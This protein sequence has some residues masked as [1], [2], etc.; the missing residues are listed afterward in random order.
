MPKQRK[1]RPSPFLDLGQVSPGPSCLIGPPTN[2]ST[3]S[4][5][6]AQNQCITSDDVTNVKNSVYQTTPA[7]ADDGSRS[8][9]YVSNNHELCSSSSSAAL[10]SDVPLQVIPQPSACAGNLVYM[11][12]YHHADFLMNCQPVNVPDLVLTKIKT[13]ISTLWPSINNEATDICPE[14]ARVYDLVK[15]T[16]LPNF[17]A[18][19]VPVPSG[20]L[21]NNWVRLL[22]NYHDNKLCNFLYFG[23]PLGY[24][25]DTIPVTVNDNH[26]SALAYPDHVDQFISTEIGF[27]ALA[28][29]TI[30]PPFTPWVRISPL[31]TR[32]KKGSD[33]RRIIVDLTYPEGSAVNSGIQLS[34]YL[35]RDITYSLPT[36][37]DLTTRL[38]DEE[39]GAL[40]WKADLARAYR[41]LRADPVDAP[42]LGIK[43]RGKIYIDKCP[44]FG[45]RSSS[46]ACQRVAN[47][48]VYILAGQH[49][50]CLAYLDD[51][52]GC[53]RE[54]H[55][56][57]KGFQA[58]CALAEHLGLQLSE[59]KCF[60]PATSVEWLGY[61]IDTQAMT[62]AIPESKLAEVIQECE[63]WLHRKRV[64][65]S[66][67]QSLAG[68]LAHVAGCVR[69]AASSLPAF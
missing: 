58:F 1:I 38:Q 12:P 29:P 45:C 50:H 35:G 24:L 22:S 9:K 55:R 15:A 26:P 34:D 10:A 7:N 42:L 49:H 28:G 25:A 4:K 6:P 62:I 47:A 31:M 13:M 63:R 8:F 68:R 16:N 5:I 52:A 2:L 69:H 43:H 39:K 3:Q 51:F 32:L 60:A 17:V 65:R 46:A 36:V 53:H 30:A 64:T 37:I 20:L 40:I 27:G 14:F 48:I 41:Q 21:V 54:Q 33:A 19:K 59:K 61:E 44:P 67:V 18:A 56:A 66:M 23:W 11:S 57:Q